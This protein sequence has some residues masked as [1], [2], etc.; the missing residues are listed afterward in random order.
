M[1]KFCLK[2]HMSVKSTGLTTRC[3][4]LTRINALMG[5]WD[6]V[7]KYYSLNWIWLK[8]LSAEVRVFFDVLPSGCV[9]GTV[10]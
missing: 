7:M 9:K 2:N 1:K 5:K 8:I 10:V 3:V 4:S 6:E